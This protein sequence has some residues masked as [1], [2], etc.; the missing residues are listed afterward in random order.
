[1]R[2]I[3]QC[4]RWNADRDHQSA[5]GKARWVATVARWW[6]ACG[7][8]PLTIESPQKYVTPDDIRGPG[9]LE[10]SPALRDDIY[11]AWCAGYLLPVAAWFS[12]EPPPDP[13]GL[14]VELG[15]PPTRAQRVLS[16][17]APDSPDA[18]PTA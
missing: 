13:D 11:R 16:A 1:M 14:W 3:H 5:A 17:G 8:A 7:S 12:D 2:R 15:A 10:L 18:S 9:R 6:A 4:A